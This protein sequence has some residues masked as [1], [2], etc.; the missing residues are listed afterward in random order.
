M[1]LRYLAL[2]FFTSQDEMNEMFLSARPDNRFSLV[3]VKVLHGKL[4]E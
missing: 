1:L 3:L 4:L 2:L